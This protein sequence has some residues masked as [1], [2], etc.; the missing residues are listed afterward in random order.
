MALLRKSQSKME[1][2]ILLAAF[3][4]LTY[5]CGNDRII[6]NDPIP[7]HDSLTIASQFASSDAVDI[8]THTT[9][10]NKKLENL[11]L[12]LE[13]KYSDEPNEQHHTFFIATKEKAWIWTLNH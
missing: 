2:I 3:V 13:W 5:S 7:K 10:L 4:A 6:F 11:N 1:N 12:G 8:S 9:A